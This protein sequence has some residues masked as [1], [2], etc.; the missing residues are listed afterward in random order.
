MNAHS[1]SIAHDSRH[2]AIVELTHHL[3]ESFRTA[4]FLHY[5]AQSVAIHCVEGLRQIHEGEVELGPHRL[6]FLLQLRDG[7]DH[8]GGPTMTAEAA[9]AFRQES[10]FQMVIEMVEEDAS[11][12]LPD[13]VQQGDASMIV[14][15]LVIPFLPLEMDN[16][17]VLEILREFSLTPHLQEERRQMIHESLAN[18][19]VNLGGDRF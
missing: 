17:G 12:D 9:L 1:S 8:V 14:T 18:V 15:D 5:F 19:L 2:N 11:E 16:C 13:D 7:D 6:T 4:E 10:L 3:S